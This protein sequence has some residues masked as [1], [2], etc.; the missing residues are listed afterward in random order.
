[1]LTLSF[2]E[3]CLRP[4]S[5]EDAPDVAD[6]VRESESTVGAWMTWATPD[7]SQ[8]EAIAWIRACATHRAEG[9]AHEFGIFSR[10]GG[11][12]VGAAGLNQFNKVNNFCNLGYWVR[13][14]A[15]C[16]GA[17]TAA[18]MALRDFAF[19]S[20][21]LT[22]LEIVVAHDNLAS[23][24]VARKVGAELECLARNRLQLRG[25]P[26]DAFVFS[27]TPVAVPKP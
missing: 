24:A 13:E 11:R 25:E 5:D 9:S 21:G 1:M 19:R 3:Y 15:H 6:A 2:G 14:S 8:V 20:L 12:L 10:L 7:Y 27:I 23:A 16:K 17:A 22:R 4:L 18:V 26:I